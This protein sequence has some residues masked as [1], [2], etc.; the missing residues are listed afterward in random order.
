[1]FARHLI[2][3]ATIDDTELRL[4]VR[5]NWYRSVPYACVEVLDVGLD[6]TAR[7]ATVDVAGTTLSPADLAGLE[8]WWPVLDALP[9]RARLDAPPAPG[10]HA[11]TVTVGTRIPYL[12][13]PDDRAVVI[14]DS[15]TT[16][17]TA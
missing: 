4:L 12:I 15:A 16:E 7:P 10:P 8:G 1:M 17:V 9:V 14:V 11:V 2:E 6:G 13:G 3:S 5:L